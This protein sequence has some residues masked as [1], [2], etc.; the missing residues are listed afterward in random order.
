[1]RK[2]GGSRIKTLY[3]RNADFNQ[4]REWAGSPARKDL[5]AKESRRGEC[6][7]C[8]FKG[9]GTNYADGTE[10]WEIQRILSPA[11]LLRWGG[12]TGPASQ[13]SPVN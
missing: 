6:T 1:M 7:L 3:F 13:H 2:K 8:P 12:S 5:R 10:E 4:L 9:I 11:P